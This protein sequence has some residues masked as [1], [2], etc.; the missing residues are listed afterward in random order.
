MSLRPRGKGEGEG[1]REIKEGRRERGGVGGLKYPSSPHVWIFLFD[2]PFP[3]HSATLPPY[4]PYCLLPVLL[5]RPESKEQG[6]D[7]DDEDDDDDD[8]DDEDDDDDDD[9]DEE[10]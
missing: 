6:D 10:A 8:D 7:D 3:H 4:L 5:A 9:D 2:M 1:R